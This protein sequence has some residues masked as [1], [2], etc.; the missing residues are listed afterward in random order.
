MSPHSWKSLDAP[1][2]AQPVSSTQS[3]TLGRFAPPGGFPR[4]CLHAVPVYRS[5]RGYPRNLSSS[6]ILTFS[7]PTGQHQ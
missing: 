7:E 4:W 5:A 6:D 3:C 1:C 2:P